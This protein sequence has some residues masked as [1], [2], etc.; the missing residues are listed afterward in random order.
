MKK[1][2]SILLV[3]CTVV[4]LMPSAVLAATGAEAKIGE[5]EYNTLQEAVN[6][7]GGETIQLL[8]DRCDLDCG[9]P[10]CADKSYTIDLT[11]G[12]ESRFGGPNWVIYTDGTSIKSEPTGNNDKGNSYN[13]PWAVQTE[14]GLMY[15]FTP[16]PYAKDYVLSTYS[17]GSRYPFEETIPTDSTSAYWFS[18]FSQALEA[19]T[20]RDRHH[21]II[22]HN[23]VY[24][25]DIDIVNGPTCGKTGSTDITV[26]NNGYAFDIGTLTKNGY[27]V[28]AAPV[29]DGTKFTFTVSYTGTLTAEDGS[30]TKLYGD[31]TENLNA[32]NS[33][34]YPVIF[35]MMGNNCSAPLDSAVTV[36][37]NVTWKIP[38]NQT[39]NVFNEL[40]VDGALIADGKIAL[41]GDAVLKVKQPVA[42]E[43]ITVT[44]GFCL[45][46]SKEGEYTVYTLKKYPVASVGG[47]EYEDIADAFAAAKGTDTPVVM[48][49]DCYY[50][51]LDDVTLDLNGFIMRSAS[52]NMEFNGDVVIMDSS[53]EKN[54]ELNAMGWSVVPKADGAILTVK[55]GTVH[56][57]N[58]AIYADKSCHITIESEAVIEGDKYGIAL[59]G[60]EA[61][62]TLIINGKVRGGSGAVTVNGLDTNKGNSITVNDPAEITAVG[63]GGAGI[64]AAGYAQ[65]NITGGTIKGS[66]ALYQKSG[67]VTV[68]GGNFIADGAKND[69]EIGSGGFVATGDAIVVDS[70]NYP[71]GVPEIVINSPD[72]K[73]ESVNA[74][75]INV[76]RTDEST[77]PAKQIITAGNCSTDPS[78]YL[79]PEYMAKK[80]KDGTF[81]VVLRP[82]DYS[83]VKKAIDRANSLKADN[84]I[85]YADVK[86]AIDAVVEGKNIK[87]QD[88]VDAYA[89][90]INKAIDA[91]KLKPA[92]YSKVNEAYDKI[93][94]NLDIYTNETADALINT[95]N[96]VVYDLDITHQEEVDGYA[97]AIMD[98]IEALK[99]KPE[100]TENH[101]SDSSDSDKHDSAEKHEAETAQTGDNSNIMLWIV[102]GAVGLSGLIYLLVI[103]R[104][105]ASK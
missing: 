90:S 41:N 42:Q 105:K 83:Q 94:E 4:A 73:L 88:I 71:G 10:M 33:A 81:T 17:K 68:S 14:D 53:N 86:K 49:Q 82:A 35:E 50:Q 55:S 60:K 2:L 26:Y 75:S 21:A 101:G 97:A 84:Y 87:E 22:L 15:H 38:S 57:N 32:A 11:A 65:W 12:G 103:R 79:P 13:R 58:A 37:G 56:G 80:E 78:E 64:Y 31:W 51:T 19:C 76:Y 43:N 95:A 9:D 5:V 36:N 61:A 77:E 100:Y 8:K 29:Q 3:L 89:E 7:S 96:A 102:L 34:A 70:C 91:L 93:P 24:A 18:D 99:L 16:N 6:A 74:D 30:I 1:C 23:D 72:V 40:T 46:E 92:D 44:D 104:I 66:T 47:T 62:K 45:N 27:D 59:D 98:A 52:G 54:G 39:V 85:N 25:G 63:E 67:K 20:G 48:L 28:N 69:Y